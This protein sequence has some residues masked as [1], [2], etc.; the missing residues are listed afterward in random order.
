SPS[1][2]NACS[3]GGG[4]V[5][6]SLVSG[7]WPNRH[8]SAAQRCEHRLRIKAKSTPDAGGRLS[9]L[10]G[11]SC[12]RDV[13][14]AHPMLSRDASFGEMRPCS[15]ARD[16]ERLRCSH[17]TAVLAVMCDQRLDL[18]WPELPGSLLSWG[19]AARGAT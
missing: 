10:V 12:L 4:R 19:R 7:P 13:S 17:H 16:P 9:V 18:V 2:T 6:L 14:I 11:R 15:L 1:E 5:L 8:S 3:V